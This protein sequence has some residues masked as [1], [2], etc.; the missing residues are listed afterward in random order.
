MSC[1][2]VLLQRTPHT[3]VWARV[4]GYPPWPA[5]VLSLSEAG[6]GE[7]LANVRFFGESHDRAALPL[8]HC[9]LL[10]RE[11]PVPVRLRSALFE[12][13]IRELKTHI[14]RLRYT[15]VT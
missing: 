12:D 5:K 11:V 2:V 9:L 8:P 7:R 13:A 10:S 4:K 3:L 1:H 15:R 14:A 6:A